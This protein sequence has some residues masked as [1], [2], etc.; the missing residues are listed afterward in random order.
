MLSFG[1]GMKQ[2]NELTIQQPKLFV[3]LQQLKRGSR[4]KAD[5]FRFSVVDI[6]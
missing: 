3:K 2:L 1:M 5:F 4:A 6:L